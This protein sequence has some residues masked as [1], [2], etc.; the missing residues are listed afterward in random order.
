LGALVNVRI[1]EGLTTVNPKSSNFSRFKPRGQWKKK[2]IPFV[3]PGFDL[4]EW[5]GLLLRHQVQLLTKAPL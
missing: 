5:Q 4:Q 2:K 1:A 3:K